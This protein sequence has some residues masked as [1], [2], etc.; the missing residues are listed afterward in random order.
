MKI[1]ALSRES[2]VK[3]IKLYNEQQQKKAALTSDIN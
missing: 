2:F 1:L 3:I